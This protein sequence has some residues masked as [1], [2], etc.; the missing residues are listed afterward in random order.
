MRRSPFRTARVRPRQDRALIPRLGSLEARASEHIHS[1]SVRSCAK[2]GC[3]RR[4]FRRRPAGDHKRRTD[5]PRSARVRPD[6]PRRSVGT[7]ACL[8]VVDDT[9]RQRAS[10]V[11]SRGHRRERSDHRRRRPQWHDPGRAGREWRL[12]RYHRQHDKPGLRRRRRSL[13]GG[14]P[15]PISPTTRRRSRRGRSSRSARRPLPSVRWTPF[16]TSP[17]TMAARPSTG[18]GSSRLWESR[19]TFPR[20]SCSRRKSTCSISRAPTATASARPRARDST[21]RAVRPHR[22][23]SGCPGIIW[24]GHRDS[25]VSAVRGIATLPGG[26]PLYKNGKLVGGIG[27]FF[28]GTTGFATEENSPLNTPLLF[29]GKKPDYAQIGEYMA[30]VA[31]GAAKTP[32]YRQTAR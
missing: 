18:R 27:V 28:P 9:R 8:A 23:Q 10:R 7:A 6:Q 4:T 13:A 22:R 2:R 20:A 17:P 11:R 16:R 26:V 5:R 21:S 29:D 1:R 14:A 25:S 24:S 30:L 15:A 31:A 3:T 32:A 12:V 19:G